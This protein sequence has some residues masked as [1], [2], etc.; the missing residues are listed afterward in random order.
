[1]IDDMIETM[2]EYGGV[3]L[4]A[5]QVHESLRIAVMEVKRNERYPYAPEIPLTVCI[6][7]EVSILTSETEEDWEGCLSV[8]DLRGRVPRYRTIQVNARDRDGKELDFI[9]EGFFARV[10]QHEN[11]HL[12]GKVF[13]DRMRDLAS[14]S[15]LAEY[16][17]Y[18]EKTPNTGDL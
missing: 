15:Y 12:N 11:D 7:P 17:R 4:A 18:G 2:R 1:L 16:L 8:I 14:L 3:G 6:N 5:P 13:L 9:A 10:I